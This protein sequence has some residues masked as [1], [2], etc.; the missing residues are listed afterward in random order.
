MLI[1]RL[2]VQ[3]AGGYA[4]EIV[5]LCQGYRGIA[6][7]EQNRNLEMERLAVLRLEEARRFQHSAAILRPIMEFGL[8]SGFPVSVS[9]ELLD[10]D[11][12]DCTDVPQFQ[13]EFARYCA[14]SLR[15]TARAANTKMPP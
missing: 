1:Q 15:T 11:P 7:F 10:I 14:L 3:D 4:D 2:A 9:A 13:S 8:E 12:K 5:K 6:S